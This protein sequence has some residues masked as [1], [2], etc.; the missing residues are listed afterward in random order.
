MSARVPVRLEHGTLR[1][2]GRIDRDV[3]PG[4]WVALPRAGWRVLDLSQV[5]GVDTAGLAMLIELLA[6]RRRADPEPP[7]VG[8]VSAAIDA[9]CR[10]YR[11]PLAQEDVPD[12]P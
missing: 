10:A 3:V 2:Y 5:D 12:A 4:L 9:L 8:G 1:L 6:R 11:W 7:V